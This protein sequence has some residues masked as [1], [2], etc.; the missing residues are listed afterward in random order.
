MKFLRIFSIIIMASF[1][2]SALADTDSACV[3]NGSGAIIVATAADIVT[4]VNGN[5]GT[6][7]KEAPD[8][9]KITFYRFG[10]CKSNP[11]LNAINDFSSC[12]YLVDS[13]AGVEHVITYPASGI[14]E[15]NSS[16]VPGTYNYLLLML[17]NS[18]EQKHTETFSTTMTGATGTGTKCWTIDKST[19]FGGNAITGTVTV[20]PDPNTRSTLAIDCGATAAP[21]YTTEIF[22]TMGGCG[23]EPCFGASD[24]ESGRFH[25]ELLKSDNVT[26]ATTATNAVRMAV[27]MPLVKVITSAS[28]YDVGFKVNGSTSFDLHTDGS[29]LT[30]LKVG[31]D[32]FQVTFNVK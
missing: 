25:I 16:I 2:Q 3:R 13:N 5:R 28:A 14:L 24:I 18:L 12:S 19:A 23:S 10:M 8:F 29:S 15:T 30:A 7:C 11:L 22:E 26:I 17:S 6:S 4:D 27:V 20:S 31:A 1:A 9:Y 32:P 21:A